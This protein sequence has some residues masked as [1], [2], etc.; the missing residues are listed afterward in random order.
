[1]DKLREAEPWLFEATGKHAKGGSASSG[2][3]GLPNAGAASD[4]GKTLEQWREVVDL[5]DDD[6]DKKN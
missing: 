6:S 1:M 2:T 4:E 3:T 5:T